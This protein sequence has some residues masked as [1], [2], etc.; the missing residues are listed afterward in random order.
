MIPD[1]TRIFNSRFVPRY[2]D[3]QETRLHHQLGQDAV[4]TL[5]GGRHLLYTCPVCRRPWYKAGRR[6]YPRL[7]AEQLAHLG[8]A[9]HADVTATYTL[10]KALCPICSA[11][12]LD[13]A[14]SIEAY[15]LRRGYHLL[16]ESAS[17]PRTM[18]VAM[19][20]RWEHG[21]LPHL[22]QREPDTLA[23]PTCDARSILDWLAI[24]SYPETRSAYSDEESQ[25]LARR[26]SPCDRIGRIERVWR[27]YSWHD[28]CPPLGD[29][30]L[31]SLVVAVSPC[32]DAPFAK[33]L[34]A[35]KALARAMR[36][37]W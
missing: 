20:H 17:P 13:G 31:V 3:D 26:L 27:G 11:V 25:L 28:R 32:E 4:P 6:E 18:L 37:V 7:T 9:L 5:E 12:H 16:W 8:A 30:A 2:F 35:W 36:I 15:P 23:A 10:P 19:I 34:M 14:F 24:C 29:A 1:D 22:L 33:L 21:S